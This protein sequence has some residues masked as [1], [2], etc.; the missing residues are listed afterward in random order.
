MDINKKAI[1]SSAVLTISFVVFGALDL[2]EN[3]LIKIFMIG[4]LIVFVLF[5]INMLIHN[6]EKD[7]LESKNSGDL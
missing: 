6:K 2:L 3:L 7:R 1:L 5:A 4:G